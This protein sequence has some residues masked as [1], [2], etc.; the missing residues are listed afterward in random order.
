MMEIR[1]HGRGGQGAKT[2]ALLVADAALAT[3]VYVQAFPEYGP[4]R[5]GAP[6]RSF[7]RISEDPITIHCAVESPKV[8]VVLDETLCASVDV[9][10]GV[11]N[12]GIIIINTALPAKNYKDKLKFK[13]KVYTVNASKIA[14]DTIGL[15]KPNTPM[16]GALMRVADIMDFDKMLQDT[17]EKLKKK[18]A[19]K[20]EIVEGNVQAIKKAYE[21]VAE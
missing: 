6:V 10:D 7:N 5:M 20:P 11:P 3:G 15:N 2:A 13:G 17:T 4:E 9:T 19:A 18:F 14:M 21:E 1:W 16:L 12:D 8:V